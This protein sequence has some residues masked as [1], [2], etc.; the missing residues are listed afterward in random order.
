MGFLGKVFESAATDES[1]KVTQQ[2]THRNTWS[3]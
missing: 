3:L 2:I 1:P